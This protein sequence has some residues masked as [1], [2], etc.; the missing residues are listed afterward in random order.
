M[1]RTVLFAIAGVL[2][3]GIILM[4]GCEGDWTS[5]EEGFN[6]SQGAGVDIN[7]SGV[8]HGA[9]AGGRIVHHT[10]GQGINQLTIRQSGNTIDV[11][12]NYGSKYAGTV[13]APGTVSDPGGVFSAGALLLQG[14]IS[15]SGHD[16]SA[17]KHVEF[18][19]VIHAVAVTDIRGTTTSDTSSQQQNTTTTTNVFITSAGTNTATITTIIIYDGFGNVIFQQ[20]TTVTTTP[21]GTEISRDTETIDNRSSETTATTEYSITEANTQYRLEGTWV[22]EGG[23]TAQVDGL[24]PATAGLITTVT[25]GTTEAA[26]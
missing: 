5:S 26:P 4:T 1:K 17:N 12:D 8:Y 16:N 10:S 13:G 9:L 7:F 3:A 20:V 25:Q 6:T 23:V 24:S 11:T 19:G 22:E 18:V 14:Q 21:S 2:S 15:F